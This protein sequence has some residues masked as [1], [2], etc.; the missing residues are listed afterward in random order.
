MTEKKPFH[1]IGFAGK[2]ESG[3]S[4]AALDA[5]LYIENHYH[6]GACTRILSF[7]YP[8][9]K[10][11]MDHFGFTRD[12]LYTSVGKTVVHPFWQ[13]TP[14]EFMQRFGDGMRKEIAADV[15][16]KVAELKVQ[17]YE[18]RSQTE[19][20]MRAVIFDDVRMPNEAEMIRRHGGKIIKM[21]R[22]DHQAATVGIANHVSE[23]GIPDEL[24]DFL[25]IN[26]G[27]MSKLQA[28]VRRTVS[29]FL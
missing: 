2:L 19:E 22:P 12:Q 10:M 17:E 16:V 18:M 27:N 23:Q 13:M 29:T 8:F 7:A 28:D 4:T 20:Y 21:V 5:A 1:I 25:V 15:W 6:L 14:R 9:K 24:V 26:D 11:M 3:K